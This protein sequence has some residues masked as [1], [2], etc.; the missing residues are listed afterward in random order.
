MD[1]YKKGHLVKKNN[2][3][4]LFLEQSL[5]NG[6]EDF[7]SDDDFIITVEPENFEKLIVFLESKT[8]ILILL[9]F[10]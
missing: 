6:A 5:D 2:Y 8:M 9:K 4:D 3:D 7:E 10:H 1:V